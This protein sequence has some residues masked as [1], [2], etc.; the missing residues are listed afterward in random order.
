MDRAFADFSVKGMMLSDL[1]L[2]DEVSEE[3]AGRP[4]PVLLSWAFTAQ[5]ATVP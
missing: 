3:L 1:H 5:E 2:T 4:V